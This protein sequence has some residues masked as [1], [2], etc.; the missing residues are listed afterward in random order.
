M[1]DVFPR[2]ADTMTSESTDGQKRGFDHPFLQACGMFLGEMMCMVAFKATLWWRRRQ[3]RLGRRQPDPPATPFS[4]FVFY[5]PALCDM[6]ATS[7][8]YIG[9]TLTYASSFQMLRGAVIIFTGL[10]SR[11]VLKKRMFAFK[12]VGIA[13]VIIGLTTVGLCDMLYSGGGGGGHNST[14]VVESAVHFNAEYLG[15][16]MRGVN[17]DL[18]TDEAHK[19]SSDILLGDVLIV[20]AQVI[21]ATQMVY[22]EKYVTKYNVPALQ[23]VG[24]EGTF[25]FLTLSTLLIPFYFIP[26]GA[27]FGNNPRHVLEDAYDG[28]YQLA[29]NPLLLTA[30]CGTVVSIAFFNFAG[31]S[32][33]KEMSAT[34]RM[35]LDS[36]RTLI[37]WGVSIGVGWQTFRALQLLGFSVL[38]LGMC[39]YNNIVVGKLKASNTTRPDKK[40]GVALVIAYS[41]QLLSRK[42]EPHFCYPV[43]FMV[44]SLAILLATWYST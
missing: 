13:F 35:V 5:P 3:V 30:F 6:T 31:I 39:V 20:C 2:W 44:S 10:L 1:R 27:K 23:A 33:T 37:I 16:L 32:V 17:T 21:V 9:L 28:L 34:T 7:I 25:G 41:V 42:V 40:C 26:V 14:G 36:V 22:E 8:Q 12:W 19:S 15:N 18:P 4:P 38:V 11:I 43:G 29:H 24:W